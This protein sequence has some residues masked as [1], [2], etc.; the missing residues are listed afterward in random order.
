M[1][2]DVKCAIKLFGSLVC[3]GIG[4]KLGQDA[5]KDGKPNINSKVNNN[6]K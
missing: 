2:E 6:G 1:N 4:V 5:I 3:L